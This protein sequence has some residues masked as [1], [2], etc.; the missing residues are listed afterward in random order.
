MS[1]LALLGGTPA[2]SVPPP[3]FEW[4]PIDDGTRAA[5]LRQLDE[6]ISIYDRSGVV[7]RLESAFVR[8][9][10]R[11]HALL[12]NS[13][14][15]A[16]HSLYVGAGVGPGDE[17][18]CPAY[19]FFATVT[20]LFHTGAVPVLVDCL[21]DGNVDPAAVEAA[22]TDRTVAVM[23]T[24]MWGLP[25]DMDA[26]IELTRRRGLLLLEDASHAFG[27]TYRG[28]RVGSFSDGTAISLQAQKPIT[29]GEGGVLLTSSDDLFYR[30][31]MFGHY[32]RRCHA[33]IPRD[34]RLARFATT[35]MGLKLRIHPLAAAIAERQLERYPDILAGREKVARRLIDGLA[36]VDGVEPVVPPPDKQSSWYALLLRYDR[37][38]LDG[39][40]IDRFHEAV[41][42]EGCIEVD[43]P[44]STRPV[45]DHPLFQS[46]EELFPAYAGARTSRPGDAPTAA[47][48]HATSMKLPVWH[49]EAGGALADAYVAAIA[50]VADNH[51][52]LL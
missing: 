41:L 5:V 37:E 10:D 34:H 9:H 7:E 33:E 31:L 42:A 24:H 27:A 21:D 30:A 16:L 44:N 51:R 46:P 28:R 3:H 25:C 13:G 48:L 22:V 11:K 32:N 49:D 17:V 50:K 52:D 39:L 43:R 8:D 1:E 40:P 26:L 19:T 18:V 36:D 20:P 6:S 4:P 23:A 38:R 12:T 15:S 47:A 2:V 35:G 29:G 14:T 45:T